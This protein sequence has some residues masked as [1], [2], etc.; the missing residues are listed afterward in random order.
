MKKIFKSKKNDENLKIAHPV[1]EPIDEK[2]E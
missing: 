2:T 1:Y